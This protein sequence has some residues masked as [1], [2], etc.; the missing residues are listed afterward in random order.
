MSKLT[1]DFSGARVLVV[2][3]SRAGIG[4]AI[5]RAFQD[6]GAHVEITGAEA[7]PAPEDQARFTYHQLDVTDLNAVRA[8]ATKTEKLDILVNGAAI[9]SR[10]EEMAPEFFQ[11]VVDVNLF[12]TFRTA[13][14]FHAQLKAAKGVLINIA[15]MYASF[16]SPRNPAYGASKAAVQQLT[17]SLAIAWA[18]DGIRVNAIAPGFIV[19]EQSAKSRTDP[20][21][22]AAVNL[23]TP[24]GRWGKPEDIAP[25]VLFLASQ[26]AG[27]MTGTCLA[28]DGGYSVV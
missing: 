16:G 25:P 12:G 13:E 27:F 18:P 10:G 1:F 24:M 5:A 7:A 26:A 15:S 21:H 2:G 28:I 6:A 3:A 14:A 19:T 9:T 11:K 8:L 22:V 23:R 20:N 4:A 17:K